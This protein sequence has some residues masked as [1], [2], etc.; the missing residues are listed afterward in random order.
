MKVEDFD[1]I[2]TKSWNIV[3]LFYLKISILIRQINVIDII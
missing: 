2:T 3:E 1:K